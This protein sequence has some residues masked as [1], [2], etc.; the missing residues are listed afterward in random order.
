M[1]FATASLALV[2]ACAFSL[3]ATPAF[4]DTFTVFSTPTSTYIADTTDYGGGNGSESTISSLGVFTF[5]HGL[6]EYVVPAEWITWG[7][8]PNTQS[9]TPYVLYNAGTSLL[10][11]L[12]S[13][14]N[15]AGFELEESDFGSAL[16]S[17]SFYDENGVLIDTVSQSVDGDAG[18]LQF[19]LEDTTAGQTIGSVQVSGG[20]SDG[21]SIAQLSAGD[22]ATTPEPSSLILLG[23]GLIGV[24]GVARRRIR[25]AISSQA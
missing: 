5:S 14:Y 11:T 17:V 7:A 3:T 20:T 4:A 25:S 8:P 10:L 23:T 16:Y 24:A 13:G 12:A 18:A 22:I 6:G 9:S 2:A 21:F 1:R 19:A 15:I